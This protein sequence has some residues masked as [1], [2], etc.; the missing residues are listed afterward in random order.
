MTTKDINEVTSEEVHDA[1]ID[2]FVKTRGL[3]REQAEAYWKKW[4]ADLDRDIAILE[5]IHE[6]KLE[7]EAPIMVIEMHPR[8]TWMMC[9]TG[10][11][12]SRRWSGCSKRPGPNS[13]QACNPTQ[14]RGPH[15]LPASSNARNSGPFQQPRIPPPAFSQATGLPSP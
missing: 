11:T 10:R 3:T 14:G 15:R 2:S 4:C 6:D 7:I 5:A 12:S 8:A 9:R 1:V 13:R